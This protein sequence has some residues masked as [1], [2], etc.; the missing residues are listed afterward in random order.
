MIAGAGRH[1]PVL[2]PPSTVTPVKIFSKPSKYGRPSVDGQSRKFLSEK[3]RAGTLFYYWESETVENSGRS[4]APNNQGRIRHVSKSIFYDSFVS[5]TSYSV[6]KYEG[7]CYLPHI[8]SAFC[9]LCACFAFLPALF[10]G[11]FPSRLIYHTFRPHFAPFMASLC[12]LCFLACLVF[13]FVL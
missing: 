5:P 10:S 13:S 6:M 9:F 1:F 8:S 7:S 12:L 4:Y 2:L 11:S 3:P